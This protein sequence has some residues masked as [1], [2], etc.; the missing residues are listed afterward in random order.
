MV[1][2]IMK[3]AEGDPEPGSADWMWFKPRNASGPE[4]DWV[5]W[6]ELH[7]CFNC[8]IGFKPD[9]T[10]ATPKCWNCGRFVKSP[11]VS[12]WV[13]PFTVSQAL[14]ALGT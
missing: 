13:N 4:I 8:D 11:K 6:R 5:S 7:Q 12:T 9:N 1:A 10:R 2:R 14:E 3:Y